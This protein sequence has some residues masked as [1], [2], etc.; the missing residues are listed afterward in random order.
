[1][2]TYIFGTYNL[3]VL[4]GEIFQS[5]LIA[6]KYAIEHQQGVVNIGKEGE[7]IDGDTEETILRRN[8]KT[9][10]DEEVQEILLQKLIQIIEPRDFILDAEEETMTCSSFSNQNAQ[11]SI[12][13]DPIDGTLEYIQ[14]SAGYSICLA[15]LVGGSFPLIYVYYPTK[16]ILYAKVGDEVFIQD[17]KTNIKTKLQ[18]PNTIKKVVYANNRVI[19]EVLTP[20]VEEGYSIVQSQ[21]IYGWDDALVGLIQ[22]EFAHCL[23]HTP[24]MRDILIGFIGVSLLGGNCIDFSGNSLILPEKGRVPEAHFYFG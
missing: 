11:A 10:I 1:M 16:G 18:P 19:P 14:G 2:G 13:I 15:L 21:E 12:I 6:G 7:L 5:F 8:A 17:M 9:K 4:A 24:Q 23:F 22:G 20:Y 3:E